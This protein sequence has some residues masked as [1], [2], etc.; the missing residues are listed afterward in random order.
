ML[1]EIEEKLTD[2]L[3]GYTF[4]YQRMNKLQD[5][6]KSFIINNI[7]PDL[8]IGCYII[9][10]KKIHNHECV[11][12]CK[13]CKKNLTFKQIQKKKQFCCFKCGEK[14]RIKK[15]EQTL[16]EKHG[17]K[18]A[19]LINR[20]KQKEACRLKYGTDYY[21][22]TEEF[23]EKYKQSCL[24][25]Y[26]VDNISKVKNLNKNRD[27]LIIPEKREKYLQKVRT[28]YKENS[29]LNYNIIDNLQDFILEE[30]KTDIV[31]RE[32][33]V[34][35]IVKTGL[36]ESHLGKYLNRL[37][38]K[39]KKCTVQKPELELREFIQNNTKM[40]IIFNNKMIIYPFELDIY[41]PQLN[42]AIEFNG[43]YWHSVNVQEYNKQL[44]KTEQCEQ[45]GIR[46]I[47]IWDSDWDS[48]KEFIQSL[49][50]LYLKNKVN[51]SEF[52][53]LIEHFNGRLP[54]DYFQTLD[55]PEYKIEEPIL[56][57]SGNFDVYKTGYLN[58]IT[59]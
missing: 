46:L 8:K 50:K 23:K 54:R 5:A 32:I 22:Q 52:Q 16:L 38:I 27:Y 26:G 43:D 19:Y 4:Q 58:P 2:G 41:I 14:E 45:K 12:Y 48:N 10:Q 33:F 51:S 57:K 55:F 36:S 20:E 21:V 35:L 47:H 49:L 31:T 29:K 56:E 25:K 7:H 59:G 28:T 39:R 30:Y 44:Y 3:S 13:N 1:K 34:D 15:T 53:K 40:D 6:E 18:N 11:L 42:L 37:K 17:V 24:E 9:Y